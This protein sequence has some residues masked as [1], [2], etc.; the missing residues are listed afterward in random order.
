MDI[1]AFDLVKNLDL[2]NFFQNTA[3]FTKYKLLYPHLNFRFGAPDGTGVLVTA[4]RDRYEG[5]FERGLPNGRGEFTYG[6]KL[7]FSSA[8]RMG[9]AAHWQ[10]YCVF[11]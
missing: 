7:R 1:L 8:M 11:N 5:Q 10:K 9:R 2:V 6:E 3:D 4:S